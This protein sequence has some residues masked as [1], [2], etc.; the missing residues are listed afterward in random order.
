[1]FKKLKDKLTEEVKIPSQKFT[2]SMQQLAQAVVSPA[3]NNHATYDTASNDNFS[4]DGDFDDTPQNSPTKKSDG[5][6]AYRGGQATPIRN[7]FDTGAGFSHVDLQQDSSTPKVPASLRSSFS[8]LASDS[9]FMFPVLESSG[10]TYN[11]QSDLES[12]SE[13]SE[14]VG[15]NVNKEQLLVAYR[16]IQQKYQKYKGR[17]ADLARHYR[18]LERDNKNAK[19][20]LTECQDKALR[21]M[22]ELKE[23]CSL[24]KQAKAHLEEV[25]RSDLEEKDHLIDTLKTKY[26]DAEFQI[27][28]LKNQVDPTQAA[29]SVAEKSPVSE[30]SETQEERL[31]KSEGQEDLLTGSDSGPGAATVTA[32]LTPEQVT[33]DAE[34]VLKEK[35]KRLE[36]LLHKCKEDITNKR[37]NI[38]QLE[39]EKHD[40]STKIEHLQQQLIAI[41]KREE[42]ASL[43]LAKNKQT[44]HLELESKEEEIKK[45]K[46]QLSSSNTQV[47][48]LQAEVTQI[49][50]DSRKELAVMRA[51]ITNAMKIEKEELLAQKKSLE[52]LLAVRERECKSY[53]DRASELLKRLELQETEL[54]SLKLAND[55]LARTSKEESRIL[56]EEISGLQNQYKHVE[57]ETGFEKLKP[58]FQ[59]VQELRNFYSQLKSDAVKSQN[60]CLSVVCHEIESIQERILRIVSE[61][62]AERQRLL[63]ELNEYKTESVN[64]KESLT[65]ACDRL[66][67]LLAEKAEVESRSL[68]LQDQMKQAN[69]KVSNLEENLMSERVS[70]QMS[71]E[72]FSKTLSRLELELKEERS[73]SKKLLEESTSVDEDLKTRISELNGLLELKE[74]KILDLAKECDVMKDK[75]NTLQMTC[76][77]FKEELEI[78]KTRD[79]ESMNEITS[80]QMLLNDKNCYVDQLENS[81]SELQASLQSSISEMEELELKLQRNEADFASQLSALK[82][83]DQEASEL[84]EDLQNKLKITSNENNTT[85][86]SL[87]HANQ[88]KERQIADLKNTIKVHETECQKYST[89]IN[90]LQS[91]VDNVSRECL[92]LQQKVE[93]LSQQCLEKDS[94]LSDMKNNN[95]ELV[96][97]AQEQESK[98]E[99]MSECIQKLEKVNSDQEQTMAA[100]AEQSGVLSKTQTDLQTKTNECSALRAQLEEVV[101]SCSE[102]ETLLKSKNNECALLTEEIKKL[103]ARQSEQENLL[104]AKY[105]EC[106]K[107]YEELETIKSEKVEHS[108]ILEEK[109]KQIESYQTQLSS[110]ETQ[111]GELSS[112]R[113]QCKKLASE[114][115]SLR[116]AKLDLN[117]VLEDE[118][119]QFQTILSQLGSAKNELEEKT[120]RL[121]EKDLE[122]TELM[123][124]IQSFTIEKEK[125]SELLKQKTLECE[126]K[127][128]QLDNLA[129]E[130]KQVEE[131]SQEL[132]RINDDRDA[133]VEVLSSEASNLAQKVEELTITTQEMKEREVDLL[134]KLQTTQD[135]EAEYVAMKVREEELLS[136]LNDA[137][138]VETELK[139]NQVELQGKVLKIKELEEENRKLRDAG[140]NL[141]EVINRAKE[142]EER[143]EKLQDDGAGLLLRIQRAEEYEIKCSLLEKEL[144]GMKKEKSQLLHEIEMLQSKSFSLET[145]SE[146]DR[147]SIP[148][149]PVVEEPFVIKRYSDLTEGSNN[150]DDAG[151]HEKYNQLS[152]HHQIALQ[153]SADTIA[154]LREEIMLSNVGRD[155][156]Q[157]ERL[158]DRDESVSSTIGGNSNGS[159]GTIEKLQQ[160]LAAVTNQ[161]KDSKKI[162]RQ[163]VDDLR[164]ILLNHGSSNSHTSSRTDN[165]E[166]ATELEYLRNILYEYMM[167]KEPMILARVIAAV[168]KFD[169]DQTNKVL[170]K[171]Q[172]RLSLL[173]HLG[174]S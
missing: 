36:S 22:T 9:S 138:T 119:E 134:S 164:R 112:L 124:Q 158:W 89:V 64:L 139:A 115:D 61:S 81:V 75:A 37:E 80:V 159:L 136:R 130:M 121:T 97:S 44:I 84:I 20:I 21:R 90:E 10:P 174:I 45:L 127:E 109:V 47:S 120:K 54:T 100:Q 101:F 117:K 155:A 146:G 173:G 107:L 154:K 72:E 116:N 48:E 172:Q 96:L 170:Q 129:E 171:E 52:D 51:E 43:S 55:D 113:E 99:A 125:I 94:I 144:E 131:L 88:E 104:Q 145:A 126:E 166:D 102:H 135:L 87:N 76:E 149:E 143:C 15:P 110:S 59:S 28:L 68:E 40:A 98:I 95:E 38:K 16:K 70:H 42:E 111:Q 128:A 160:Q 30:T 85:V 32:V 58:I 74:K 63:S 5:G 137:Q 148:K 161:L 60:D 153:E 66:N 78:L 18:D 4:I 132:H 6:V 7:S 91:K 57:K 23:Q 142:A 141:S 106:K 71:E 147:F 163:E 156:K 56:K 3:S 24:E 83:K 162:H 2:Q 157:K 62:T 86:L 35:V 77:Q 118:R 108:V 33:L 82:I 65:S 92:E 17:Y 11:F 34:N 31:S 1:M 46:K 53:E 73:S 14:S 19:H 41:Q 114:A 26:C 152:Q 169:A 39:S 168:V 165:L 150:E 140:Q 69:L 25:L 79:R 167:G 122:C 50:E 105:N 8:S 93:E 12:C 29:G 13:A 133:N 103:T 49:K 123:S 151:W 27:K 67:L